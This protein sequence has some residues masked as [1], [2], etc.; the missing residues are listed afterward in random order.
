MRRQRMSEDSCRAGRDL[1]LLKNRFPK[2]Y[3]KTE[4][5]EEMYSQIAQRQEEEYR[6]RRRSLKTVKRPPKMILKVISAVA[7]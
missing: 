3:Q 6:S 7:S 2:S 5:V 4:P 1:H